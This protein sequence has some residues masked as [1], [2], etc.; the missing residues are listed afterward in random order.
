MDY[1]FYPSFSVFIGLFL[2]KRFVQQ[3][4]TINMLPFEFP[5]AL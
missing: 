4:S 2:K 1:A 3:K 5:M